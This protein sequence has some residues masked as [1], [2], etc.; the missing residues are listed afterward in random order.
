MI[1]I[2]VKKRRLD[3]EMSAGEIKKRLAEWKAP[4]PRYTTG[5]FAKYAK[6]VSDASAGAVTS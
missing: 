5:V 2:D 6:T 4:R 1:N 3:V